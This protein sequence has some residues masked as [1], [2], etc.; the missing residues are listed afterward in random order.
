LQ[1]FFAVEKLYVYNIAF[2]GLKE[3]VHLFDYSVGDPFFENFE[4]SLVQQAD[5]AVK[6]ALEKRSLFM[7]LALSFRGTV[8]LACDRCLEMYS[9]PVEGQTDLWIRFGSSETDEPDDVILLDPDDY[10][11]NVA[12]V[13]YDYICLAIPL[14]HIHPDRE[15]GT[16]GCDPVMLKKLEELS[17]PAQTHGDPRWNQLK[18]MIR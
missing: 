16:S 14:K 7:K 18:G 8:Q 1:H 2:K 15:D 10:Q 6:I 11:F 4:G 3:G 17:H 12:K 13:I 9:Q 5:V